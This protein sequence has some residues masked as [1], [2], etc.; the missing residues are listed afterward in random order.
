MTETATT[1]TDVSANV[2]TNVSTDTST[3]TN[4]APKPRR[5]RKKATKKVD[6]NRISDPLEK[7]ARFHAMC[8]SQ[9]VEREVETRLL[10]IGLVA[11]VNVFFIGE[12]GVAKSMLCDALCE[13]I[14]GSVF[15]RLMTK[16]TDPSELFGP[17]SIEEFQSSR[18]RRAVDHY[19][20]TAEIAFLDE[21]WKSSSAVINN[22][23]EI[24]NEG[25]YRNGDVTLKVPLKMAIAA[26]N[27][28][29]PMGAA[30]QLHAMY[31]RFLI[32]K[33]VKSVSSK[34]SLQKICF[35]EINL[36]VDKSDRLTPEEIDT[37][38]ATCANMQWDS[39]ASKQYMQALMECKSKG[40]VPSAR[41]ARQA[42]RACAAQALIAGNSEVTANDLGVLEHIL[43]SDPKHQA[44]CAD[45]VGD[46]CDPADKERR[47]I[48][49]AFNEA[50]NTISGKEG[51]WQE[52]MAFMKTAQDLASRARSAG[53][54]ELSDSITSKADTI[55]DV[56]MANPSS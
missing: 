34:R 46:L 56:G 21:I 36:T 29:P 19:L 49:K 48:S 47:E 26:S 12:P 37:L 54:R 18:F 17:M 50:V 55:K 28:Y 25:T 38:R 32:R 23:L 14:D 33:E 42:T 39:N 44:E 24:L 53:H 13:L 2:S 20:P 5:R 9:L 6:A 16:H 22:L 1:S 52:L 8:D 10:T 43:W 45:I 41:R 7:I 4:A 51:Q 40:I 3:D 11:G 35:S 27:E 15:R 30:Q 31:D